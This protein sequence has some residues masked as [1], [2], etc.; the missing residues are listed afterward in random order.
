MK[1]LCSFAALVLLSTS[2][3]AGTIFSFEIEGRV[4][5]IN[6]PNGCTSLECISV[7]SPEFHG[8]NY[9]HASGS[10]LASKPV[11]AKKAKAGAPARTSNSLSLIKTPNPEDAIVP[12]RAPISAAD[13]RPVVVSA[14]PTKA[15]SIDMPTPSATVV[16]TRP[17]P[18]DSNAASDPT[19]LT[20]QMRLDA[21]PDGSDSPANA[22]ATASRSIL[23]SAVDS[24]TPIT[25][26]VYKPVRTAVEYDGKAKENQ[27][28]APVEDTIA[29]PRPPISTVNSR[30]VVV[31]TE[32]TKALSIDLVVGARPSAADSPMPVDVTSDGSASLAN[33]AT[34]SPRSPSPSTVESATPTTG[35]VYK[36]VQTA[37]PLAPAIAHYGKAKEDQASAPAVEYYR[38]AKENLNRETSDAGRSAS[39][40]GDWQIEGQKRTIHIEQCDLFVCGYVADSSNKEKVLIDLKPTSSSEWIGLIASAESNIMYPSV[41]ILEDAKTLRV[42]ACALGI[43]FCEGQI[44]T[45]AEPVLA[46]VH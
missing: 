26:S 7:S 29:S 39:L 21:T 11:S 4:V 20:R 19:S 9:R 15:P 10:K 24:A 42:R 41:V 30:S 1:R 25:G 33:A 38:K 5:H 37:L 6:A 36:P 12:P 2:A 40:L 44:W 32:P 17:S 28:S 31:S 14:E 34:T 13:S 22:V 3:H 8:S 35:S 45:R 43:T 23:P 18:T 46:G 16:G 27:T